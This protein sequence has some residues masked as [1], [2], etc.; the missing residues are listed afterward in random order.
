MPSNNAY[1]LGKM[2][3]INQSITI[4]AY[5]RMYGKVPNPAYPELLR[6]C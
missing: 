1:Y 4:R 3:F 6:P 5:N 2:P